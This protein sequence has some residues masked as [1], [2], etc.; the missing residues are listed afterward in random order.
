[1]VLT[2]I[3]GIIYFNHLDKNK[4]INCDIFS[5]EYISQL[6][7]SNVSSVNYLLYNK[8][9][10]NLPITFI[11]EK[12]IKNYNI[13]KV[14]LFQNS[15]IV[16][17]NVTTDDEKI[18]SNK[19][20][21]ILSEYIKEFNKIRIY[22]KSAKVVDINVGQYYFDLISI[23]QNPNN[24]LALDKY[25]TFDLENSYEGNFE[26]VGKKLPKIELHIPERLKGLNIL[27]QKL[28]LTDSDNLNSYKYKYT[29]TISKE[30]FKKN[31]LSTI[32]FDLVFV[33]ATDINKKSTLNTCNVVLASEGGKE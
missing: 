21:I 19:M 22:T 2:F 5:K 33:D 14:E 17:K 23:P 26:F 11:F 13:D 29:C 27:Q 10:G 31:N 24:E 18:D 12:N 4:S 30:Y 3:A 32:C 9:V 6:E 28:Q 15:S 25:H 20:T 16:T 7:G 1:M 8:D